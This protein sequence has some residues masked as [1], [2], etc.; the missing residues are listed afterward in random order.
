M[1]KEEYKSLR[2]EMRESKRYVFERPLIILTA[3]FALTKFVDRYYLG[4]LPFVTILLL[5]FNLWF[6]VNRLRSASRIAAYIQVVHECPSDDRWFGWETFLRFQRMW[7]KANQKEKIREILKEKISEEAVPDALFY[8]PAIFIFHMTSVII[9]LIF[10]ISY[11]VN[12]FNLVNL[13][14]FMMATSVS[15]YFFKYCY[16]FRPGK[17][18]GLIEENKV[19]CEEVLNYII[20]NKTQRSNLE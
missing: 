6:T 10:S 14:A 19:I 16:T 1:I 18:T 4:F 15:L 17:M 11:T 20:Q 12:N 3:I 7:L 13:S 8:Y 9:T 2:D 5:S